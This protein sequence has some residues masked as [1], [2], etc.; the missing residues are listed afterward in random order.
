MN[1]QSSPS[2]V[3]V[4]QLHLHNLLSFSEL[5]MPI[6]LGPLNI[7]IG[8][9]GCGKSNVLEAL[10]LL[11]GSAT[12]F[13]DTIRIGGGMHAWIHR[14]VNESTHVRRA[15]I[16]AIVRSEQQ[17]RP[18]LRHRLTFTPVDTGFDVEETI[19]DSEITRDN[20]SAPY[21]YFRAEKGRPTVNTREGNRRTLRV[22]EI[23]RSRSIVAQKND[24]EFYPELAYLAQQYRGF[25]FFRDWTFGR[26]NASR[27]AQSVSHDARELSADASN[28]GLVLNRLRNNP[29]GKRRMR[30]EL[31]NVLATAT[32]I[33]IDIAFGQFQLALEENERVIPAARLSDGTLRY[34]SLLCMLLDPAPPKLLVIEEPELGL[35]PD[36]IQSVARLLK[37]A[38][39]HTQIVLTTHSTLLVD[40]FS[41]APESILVLDSASGETAVTRCENDNLKQWLAAFGGSLSSLWMSGKI[42]GTRW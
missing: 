11:A 6:V 14:R 19:E 13:D 25:R 17:G 9:N 16:E 3:F 24:S 21:F 37:A 23:D 20:A 1:S 2:S 39:A 8:P 12:K 34:L 4:Q 10:Q 36:A 30:A 38:S 29:E 28:L 41:D 35:H 22:E 7:L 5:S 33:N 18:P 27:V 15:T 40:A 31:Q 26:A 32:D 42:G